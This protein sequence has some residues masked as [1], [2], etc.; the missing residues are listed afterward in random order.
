MAQTASL[1]IHY[2]KGRANILGW[3]KLP[4]LDCVFLGSEFDSG[5]KFVMYVGKGGINLRIRVKSY[6]R[7]A[8]FED[9]YFEVA[10]RSSG[11]KMKFSVND[12]R[13]GGEWQEDGLPVKI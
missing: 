6:H 1:K 10:S 4:L 2:L 12:E 8:Y 9:Y 11:V 7:I 13:G 5:I 3:R